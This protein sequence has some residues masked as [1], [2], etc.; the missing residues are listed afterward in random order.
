MIQYL[1]LV[2]LCWITDVLLCFFLNLHGR[3][4]TQ[5][6]GLPGYGPTLTKV[7]TLSKV[8]TTG[9]YST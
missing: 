4:L 1:D 2:S 3:W 6:A 8:V 5:V 9:A 7:S